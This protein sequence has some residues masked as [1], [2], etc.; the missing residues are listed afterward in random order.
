VGK[1]TGLATHD[2]GAARAERIRVRC[3]A[4]LARR[5]RVPKL[6]AFLWSPF[7]ER[8][9][10]PALVG[11]VAIVFLAEVAARALVLYGF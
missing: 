7:V 9:L 5:R 3:H 2:V 11:G 1:L 4:A 8:V 10:E 6:A